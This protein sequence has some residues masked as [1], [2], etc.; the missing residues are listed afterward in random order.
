ML[1]LFKKQWLPDYIRE[2]ILKTFPAKLFRVEFIIGGKSVELSQV[3]GNERHVEY[4]VVTYIDTEGNTESETIGLYKGEVSFNQVDY[5]KDDFALKGIEPGVRKKPRVGKKGEVEKYRKELKKK[6]SKAID[7]CPGSSLDRL[8]EY[9][10]TDM[11]RWQ[12]KRLLNLL[13]NMGTEGITAFVS[14]DL[15][16]ASLSQLEQFNEELELAMMVENRYEPELDEED[17]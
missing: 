11:P 5:A 16:N 4:G 17:L 8:H 14:F 9:P 12:R 7:Y 15:E 6:L 3:V 10:I 1:N 13:S 2:Y